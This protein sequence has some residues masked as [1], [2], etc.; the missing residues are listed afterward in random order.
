MRTETIYIELLDE[1]VPTWRPAEAEVLGDGRYRIIRPD[2]YD[3]EVEAWKFIPGTVVH[4]AVQLDIDD[5]YVHGAWL[6]VAS[7]R[8]GSVSSDQDRLTCAVC[9]RTTPDLPPSWWIYHPVEHE[10]VIESREAELRREVDPDH[11]LLAHGATAIAECQHGD[12]VLYRLAD[13]R[14]AQVLLTWSYGREEPPYPLTQILDDG[15]TAEAAARR[16]GS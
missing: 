16:H 15:S 7:K 4:G 6:L 5:A 10:S 14:Y 9:T 12:E 8:C 3:P 2:D 13:G 1:G 11:G